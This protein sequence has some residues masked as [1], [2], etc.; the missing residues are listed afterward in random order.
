MAR[1]LKKRMQHSLLISLALG[2]ALL[3]IFGMFLFTE[4]S[5]E[6]EKQINRVT[7]DYIQF[8]NHIENFFTSNVN[9][10]AGFSAYIQTFEQYDEKEMYTYIENLTKNNAE[11]IKNIGIIEDTTIKLLYPIEGNEKALGT[12]L[13]KIPDQVASA[14]YVKE[15]LTYCF[16]GPKQL[17]QG[18]TGYFI[19]IPIMKDN[20]YWGMV[21][22]VLKADKVQELFT[23]YVDECNL[24][25]AIVNKSNGSKLIFGDES[26]LKRDHLA[27]D[28]TFS[29]N[30]WTMYVVSSNDDSIFGNYLLLLAIFGI[31]VILFIVRLTYNFFCDTE[32][33]RE[34]NDIL[35]SAVFRDRLTGIYNRGFLDIRIQEEMDQSN[36]YGTP[37][38]IV[39]FDL[40]HF[41]KV[42]DTFGHGYGDAVLREISRMVSSHL[43]S[44]DVLARWGGE[45][46]AILMPC[47]SLLD[48][49]AAAEIIR[50]VIE[51]IDHNYVGKVTASFGVAEYFKDEYVGSWF[52]RVDQALYR[53]KEEG[54]NR[55]TAF[56][57]S[58]G[59]TSVQYRIEW[60]DSWNSGNSLIDADHKE[61]LNLG[62]H[63]VEDSYSFNSLE[64]SISR[65]NELLN[66]ILSHLEKEEWILEKAGYE[67][68][69]EHKKRHGEIVQKAV[70]YREKHKEKKVDAQTLFQFLLDEVINGHLEKEDSLYF[71][72]FTTKKL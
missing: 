49:T 62:N 9:L 63:L 27:F 30:N 43:R 21:S 19:R 60:S 20:T 42:N 36:R 46:F 33:I 38:S 13:S 2:M 54:R 56:E 28:S 72:L 39:Y 32:R 55:V 34:K 50:A 17:V 14:L 65:Y 51:G 29:G 11:Y 48:A 26:I 7:H 53:S 4:A 16:D 68:L 41:K 22:I 18:G 69:A 66:H 35:N 3:L 5:R 47:T 24:Q 23:E 31:L 57:A 52:K 40:D 15:H 70:D 71:Y 10:M 58:D 59:D 61:L 45:E 67:G 64:E 1:K 37:L 6:K 8:Q 25:V 12:D 44:S